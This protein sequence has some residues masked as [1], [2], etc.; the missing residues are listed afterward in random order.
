MVF[1]SFSGRYIS[2]FD[3]FQSGDSELF[4]AGVSDLFRIQKKYT[5]NLVGVSI[6]S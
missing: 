6:R 4:R 1:R 3:L 5:Y 2:N